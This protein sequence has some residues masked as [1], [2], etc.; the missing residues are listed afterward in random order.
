MAYG[1]RVKYARRRAARRGIRRIGRRTGRR[2]TGGRSV[3]KGLS[4]MGG[5]GRKVPSQRSNL[6]RRA[7]T[8]VKGADDT[9]FSVTAESTGMQIRRLGTFQMVGF[10][11]TPIKTIGKYAYHQ[12]LDYQSN[13][14]VQ[15]TIM[16]I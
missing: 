15:N 10:K 13:Q 9:L 12:S 8:Y 4:A 3:S 2:T 5:K 7:P 14:G 11:P 1:K 16:V 6:P